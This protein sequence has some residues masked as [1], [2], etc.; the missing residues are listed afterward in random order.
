MIPIFLFNPINGTRAKNNLPLQLPAAVTAPPEPYTFSSGTNLV[1]IIPSFETIVSPISNS[2]SDVKAFILGADTPEGLGAATPPPTITERFSSFFASLFVSPGGNPISAKTTSK[3]NTSTEPASPASMVSVCPRVEFD[4]DGDCLADFSRWQ[5]NSFQYK[6][7]NSSSENYTTFNIGASNS[8][9]APADFDADGRFDIA[10]F[11]AGS[12]SIHRSSKGALSMSWGTTGDLPYAGD[13]DGDGTADFAVYR[14]STHIF[15]ILTSGSNYTSYTQ[16]SLGSSGDIVVPGDF[17]GDGKADCAVFRPSNG[18]WFYQPSSGGSVIEIAWGISTDIPA[19]G[20]FDSDGT[21]DITIFRPST[22]TWYVHKS[23]GG[24]PNYFQASWGNYGDQPVPADYDGDGTTDIAI[25]RPTT[26]AWWVLNSSTS[27]K[28]Y[29][30]HNLGTGSDTAV[31]SAYLKQTGAELYADQ[32]SPARIAPINATGKTNY[33]SRNFAWGTGLV[34]LRGR[35]EMDLNIGL[36]YNSLVWTK[37]GSTMVFDADRSNLAPGFNFGFSRIEP[38]YV[39]SQTSTLSYLMVSPSGAKTEFRQTA[40]SDTYESADS[41]YAQVKINN[42][43]TANNPTEVEDITLTVTGADGTQMSYAWIGNA[44]RCTEIKDRNGN[45]L[46]ISNN[47]DGLLTSITDTLGRIVNINY[48]SYGRVSS[49]TQ[50]WKTNNGS[51]STTTHTWAS[52]SY[53]TKSIATNFTGGLSV[54]GPANGT[55]ISVLDKVTYADGSYTKFSYNDYAQVFKISNYAYNNNLLNHVWRNIE[56]FSSTPLS[57]C[58]R[59]SQTK[60]KL[61]NFNNGNEVTVKNTFATG[62]TYNLPDNTSATGA[63]IEIKTPDSAGTADALVTVIYSPSSGW[64]E[65]LPVLTED[66]ATESSFLVKKRWN[67]SIYTQENTNLAYVKN[68]RVTETKVSDDT[69][70]K[71]TKIYYLMQPGSS[72]VTKYGLVEK[73]AIYDE[74]QETVL[75]TQTTSYNDSS[76]YLSR[77]IIGLPLETKLYE[78]TTSGTLVSK[79]TYDYDENGYSETGQSVTATQHDSSNYGT[80]FNYRGNLTRA[81]RWDVSSGNSGNSSLAVSSQVKFNIAGSPVSQTDSRGRVSSF[82]YTDVWNDSVSRATYAY[83]TTFTDSGGFSSTVKY[84]YDIGANVWARSPAPSGSNNTYGKTTSRTYYDTTGRLQINKIENSI[85]GAYERYEYPDDGISLNTYSTVVDANNDGYINSSDEVLTETLFDGAGR[86]RKTRTENPESTGGFSGKL[87]EYTVLGQVKRETVATEIDSSWNPAEDDFRGM[88]GNDFIWLWNSREYDWK[89]RVTKETNTDGTDRLYSYSGCG[90]AGGQITTVQGEVTTAIDASGS[91]QTAKRRTEKI[92]ADA[93]GRTKKTEIWDLDGAGGTPYSTTAYAYN[94]RDQVT[95]AIE[96]AGSTSSTIHQD[97][98]MIYDGH[99]RLSAQHRPEQRNSSDAATYTTYTY[100]EDDTVA[101]ITDPRGARTTYEYGHADN[102]GNSENRALLTK[103]SYSLLQSNPAIPVPADV[104]FTYDAAANR[105]YMSDGTGNQTYSYDELSR[106]KIEAKNFSDTIANA[107]SGGYQLHYDYHPAGGLKSLGFWLGSNDATPMV[108]TYAADKAGRVS[109]IGSSGFYNSVAEV[110]SLAS[111]ISYRAFGGVKFM[112]YDTAQPTQISLEYNTRLQPLS[113]EA[114]SQANNTDIQNTT[115]SYFNDGS[116]KEVI[117]AVDGNFSQY[118]DF[119]FA[120]RMRRNEFGAG[121]VNSGK[122]YKQT[123][124]YDAFN[125]ITSRATW[126]WGTQRSF[127]AT[128]ANNRKTSGGYQSSIDSFDIAG[129]IV[130]SA[131]YNANGDTIQQWKFDAAGRMSDWEETAPYIN[132][133]KDIGAQMFFDGDGRVVKTINRTRNR[134]N[135]NTNYGYMSE[136]DIY[137]SVTGQKISNLTYTGDRLHTYAYLGNTVIADQWSGSLMFKFNTP[138]TGS[139]EETLSSGAINPNHTGKIEMGALGT[140]I[141]SQN[142]DGEEIDPSATHQGGHTKNPESGC[143][144]NYAWVSCDRQQEYYRSMGGSVLGGQIIDVTVKSSRVWLIR[145]PIPEDAWNNTRNLILERGEFLGWLNDVNVNFYE[146]NTINDQTQV[147][148]GPAK[149][150]QKESRKLQE[151]RD[152]A[153]EE[154]DGEMCRKFLE[155][156]NISRQ[157]VIDALYNHT[158]Y[159]AK[160]SEISVRESGFFSAEFINII[161][162]LDR[163]TRASY[164]NALDTSLKDFIKVAYGGKVGAFVSHAYSNTVFYKNF[165]SGVAFHESL[166]LAT[167]LNDVGLAEKLGLGKF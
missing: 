97:T 4:F 6:I 72:T 138:V 39:S 167:G 116:P 113:Y 102:A 7:Y 83:P 66:Y 143:Q 128:Y 17:D 163:T 25:Y 118:Y 68:P 14:P 82:S 149:L 119:D 22:G 129:N 86:V 31:P 35:S 146:T 153:K 103:I 134:A 29:T 132:T 161:P 98:L 126:T 81:T 135:G 165:K 54:F 43:G 162:T 160:R 20:D 15:W 121:N 1:N 64:A 137:S 107:P 94:G 147:S 32:L 111:N 115:Y 148:N 58:P 52:F 100:N 133:L 50:N 26:G 156:H 56:T 57:D 139:V 13:Y 67:W 96:Y 51:G 140:V 28:P 71:R 157:S 104:S 75:K 5:A 155:E 125:H 159:S 109:S 151:M 106:L 37:V 101:T 16:T 2:Y 145:G 110:T 33:Y 95:S 49:I 142:G 114:S 11:T 78:G 36:S 19:P 88:N 12:W 158:A 10:V 112:T 62:V 47:G 59:F 130:Q 24:S 41:S 55:S 80:S 154:S 93:L 99:G 150:T 84:R 48:D 152:K 30:I 122:P 3:E 89:G 91:Q 18:H 127:T 79:L 53:T 124:G 105:T 136:Y 92:Y 90:C 40:A 85:S 74:G 117:N 164:E 69:N 21:T 70:T 166:H 8:K 131:A 120:G 34:S 42:P 144:L 63:A 60:T 38:S 76:N 141:P 23:S 44:Y 46:T 27:S 65:S 123:L 61:A 45:Y 108:V 73:V 9:I 77:R 87:V